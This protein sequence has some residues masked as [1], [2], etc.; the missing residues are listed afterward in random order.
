M[1]NKQVIAA[2]EKRVFE[3]LDDVDESL[4]GLAESVKDMTIQI[5]KQSS[6]YQADAK[7]NDFKI[8]A[9]QRLFKAQEEQAKTIKKLERYTL[10]EISTIK[11]EQSKFKGAIIMIKWFLG[12]IGLG[13]V[14][15]L[16]KVFGSH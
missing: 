5:E 14:A 8:E 13:G 1:D 2:L 10:Q 16:I 12:F 7:I 11:Q 6:N 15:A 9:L 3:R 4:K